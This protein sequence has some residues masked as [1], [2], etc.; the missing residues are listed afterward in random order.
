MAAALRIAMLG[1]KGCPPLWGGIER[2]VTALAAALV[3]RGHRVTVYARAP[4]RREARARGLAAPPGVR[5]RV[6]PAVHTTHLEALTHTLAAAVAA[7]GSHDVLHFHGIGPGSV[8]A[9]ARFLAPRARRVLTVHALDWQRA[10]WEPW[11][12]ALLRRGEAVAVR[13]AHRV[14][15]VSADIAGYIEERYG[16]AAAVIR[17]G[18]DAPVVRPPGPCLAALGLA[19][20]R[21]VLCVGRLVPEK[22][23]HV[24]LDAFARLRTD[25]RLVVAGPAQDARYARALRASSSSCP[26][27]LLAGAF[28][29][30]DLEELYSHAGAFA[31]PS[32]TEGFPIALLE[33]VSYGLPVV[34]SDIPAVREAL[35]AAGAEGA[36]LCAAG[37]AGELAAC[38]ARVLAR[39][40]SAR[41]RASG[42]PAGLSWDAA[43]ARTEQVYYE[44][45]ASRDMA[46]GALDPYT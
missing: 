3:A 12:Q 26:R 19:P 11:A 39:P 2:H 10:K 17:N 37:D 25:W 6:L 36:E 7:A 23:I 16:I 35:A 9:L 27:I 42:A 40:E 44:T 22:G 24:L 28:Q 18:V 38:L 31:L 21:Y 4:Y 46:S 32:R 41:G 8:A 13:C 30:A 20:R 34:A 33:A 45:T 14:I 1:Q 29:G 5:V 43:A 15:A